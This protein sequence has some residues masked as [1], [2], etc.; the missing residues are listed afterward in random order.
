MAALQNAV[1]VLTAVDYPLALDFW[2]AT[3]GFEGTDH[4]NFATLQRDGV[5]LFLSQV[6]NQLIPDNTMAWI[7][8]DDVEG[9][10][11]DWSARIAASAHAGKTRV[12]EVQQ[13]PWGTEF[14]IVDPAGN[15]VHFA[16]A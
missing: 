6:D 14:V 16:Q 10:Y 5:D 7:R 2:R 12:V 11:S 13:Q 4:D 15:C 1:P 9:L 8:T 3:L